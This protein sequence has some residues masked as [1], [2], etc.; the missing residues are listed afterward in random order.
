MTEYKIPI[1][2]DLE[3]ELELSIARGVME[4]HPDGT[5]SMSGRKILVDRINGLKVEIFANEHS[6]PHFR[7]EFQGSTANFRISDGACI[8]GS[9]DVMRYHGNINRWWKINKSTL[10]KVWNETRPLNCPVGEYREL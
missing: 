10:I 8:N 3:D 2:S 4:M 9:G 6:P 1:P 5:Y 7:V